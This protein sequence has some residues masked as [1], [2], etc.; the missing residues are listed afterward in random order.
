VNSGHLKAGKET[1]GP[2]QNSVNSGNLKAGKETGGP[3]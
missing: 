1:D 3:H 2:H